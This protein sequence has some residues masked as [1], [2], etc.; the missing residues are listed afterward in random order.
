MELSNLWITF[1]PLGGGGAEADGITQ[2]KRSTPG[3]EA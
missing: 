1:P 3:Q 2:M